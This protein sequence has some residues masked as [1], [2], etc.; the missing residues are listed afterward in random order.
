L[1]SAIRIEIPA[2]V[3]RAGVLPLPGTLSTQILPPISA[4]SRDDMVSPS[5]VPPNFRA[6]EVS[7]WANVLKNRRLLSGAV[8]TP[9]IRDR[10][11]H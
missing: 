10:E 11:A 1:S 9:Q 7:A 5:P 3:R 2:S 8:P 4:T 6:V